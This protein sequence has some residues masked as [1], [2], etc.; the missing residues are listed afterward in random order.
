MLPFMFPRDAL[1]RLNAT[2]EQ[3]QAEADQKDDR[4]LAF[5]A[6]NAIIYYFRQVA[7]NA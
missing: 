5:K 7:E 1:R 6:D 4:R 2:S 3:L